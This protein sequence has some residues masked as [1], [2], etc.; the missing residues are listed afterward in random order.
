MRIISGKKA[1][2][3]LLE[4]IRKG[5]VFIYD[6]TP[7]VMENPKNTSTTVAAFNLRGYFWQRLQKTGERGTVYPEATLSLGPPQGE[8]GYTSSP[9]DSDI[10]F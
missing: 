10:P 9:P 2:T 6:G 7:Y 3:T 1:D 5:E 8:A 4:N